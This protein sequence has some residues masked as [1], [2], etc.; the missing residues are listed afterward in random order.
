MK[1][2][3]AIR[4]S[5]EWSRRTRLRRNF[6]TLTFY[7]YLMLFCIT[8]IQCKKSSSSGNILPPVTQEGKNTFGC[9]VNGLVWTPYSVCHIG[10]G[11]PCREL[12]F[13][14]DQWDSLHKLPIGFVL[15]AA[16]SE[17]P[18]ANSSFVFYALYPMI[19]R[20]G[21]VADSLVIIYYKDSTQYGHVPSASFPGSFNITKLDTVNQIVA[22][23]FSF[24]LYKSGG[25]SVVITDGRFDLTYNVCHCH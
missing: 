9:R 7:L 24:V 25:D 4:L 19:N 17:E 2:N 21:N 22:G 16:R 23:V 5:P 12:G 1:R 15:G 20:T 11:S 13:Q 8:G 18:M 10:F 6:P 14:V 3:S